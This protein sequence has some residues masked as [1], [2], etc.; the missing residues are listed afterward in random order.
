MKKQA[1]EEKF[2]RKKMSRSDYLQELRREMADEPEEVHMG[3]KKKGKFI[4]EMEELEEEEL[5]HFKRKS[6]TKQEMKTLKRKEREHLEEKLDTLDDMRDILNFTSVKHGRDEE[7]NDV[8]DVLRMPKQKKQKA[9]FSDLPKQKK[10]I[11]FNDFNSSG[12]V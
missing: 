10:R 12:N 9:D 8:D 6:Y 2:Q 4:R 11:T 7:T 3:L 5:T 1:R